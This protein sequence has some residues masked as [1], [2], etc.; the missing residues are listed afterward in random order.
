M[1]K[2]PHDDEIEK[3]NAEG[4]HAKERLEDFLKRREGEAPPE[5]ERGGGQ[6]EKGST[7]PQESKPQE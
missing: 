3:S 6:H 4:D 1:T 5:V 2:G 7:K